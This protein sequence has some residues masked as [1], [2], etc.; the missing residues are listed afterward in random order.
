MLFK[1][2]IAVFYEHRTKLASVFF[3][4][5]AEIPTNKA[6]GTYCYRWALSS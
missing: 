4:Q 3:E 6:G 1:K 2:I 5:N